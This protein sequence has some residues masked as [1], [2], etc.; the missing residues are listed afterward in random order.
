M[1]EFDSHNLVSVFLWNLFI[2]IELRFEVALQQTQF[3][4]VSLINIGDSDASGFLQTDEFAQNTLAFDNA[5]W[6]LSGSAQSWKETNQLDWINIGS[7]DDQFGLSLFDQGGNLVEAE[8]KKIWLGSDV[9]FS[10]FS[11]FGELDQSSFLV[12]LVLWGVLVKKT[13]EFLGFKE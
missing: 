4:L 13:V 11:V 12:F 8:F 10:F 6:G 2:I 7:D 9:L 3:V 5:E 1:S